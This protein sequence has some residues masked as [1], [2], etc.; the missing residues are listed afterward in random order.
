ML[1]LR[2]HLLLLLG[3]LE[4]QQFLRVEGVQ[5]SQVRDLFQQ[6][7]EDV[8]VLG[9]VLREDCLEGV[10]QL[11][12]HALDQLGVAQ[13]RPVGGDHDNGTE[14]A[15][16]G[17]RQPQRVHPLGEVEHR[18]HEETGVAA[19]V[20]GLS[21]QHLPVQAYHAVRLGVEHASEPDEQH[22]ENARLQQR[23]LI[24]LRQQAES[25]DAFREFDHAADRGR[26]PLREILQQLLLAGQRLG[27][28]VQG[29]C[30][31]PQRNRERVPD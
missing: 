20:D 14:E 15:E 5:G 26:E 11:V 25:R 12:V 16:F 18:V 4:R 28:R 13:P 8:R 22:L 3:H 24:V 21:L 29:A 6:L 17:V 9:M 10:P 7:P 1:L 23:H 31:Q 19:V 27:V 30:L 2:L